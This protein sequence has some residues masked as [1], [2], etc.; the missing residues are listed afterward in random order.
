MNESIF[1]FQLRPLWTTD[2]TT[3][4][5]SFMM[6]KGSQFTRFFSKEI[7]RLDATGNLELLFSRGYKRNQQCKP[8]L[9][10]KPLGYEKLA[11]LFVMLMFGCIMSI[12]VA[13]FEYKRQTKKKIK[14]LTKKEKEMSLIEEKIVKNLEGLSNQETKNI[15]GRL[16]V[17]LFK[18]KKEDTKLN[19]IRSDDSNFNFQF[20]YRNFSL[21]TSRLLTQRNSI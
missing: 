10:E 15:L 4:L 19:I 2:T 11:F 12:S 21:K 1:S 9:K 5:Y 7:I 8:L 18:K 16:F 3:S 6:K 14:E 20:G 17:K 13:Y